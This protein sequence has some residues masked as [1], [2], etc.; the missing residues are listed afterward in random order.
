MKNLTI[1]ML[2]L[3]V[4]SCSSIR[5]TSDFEKSTD[6]TAYKTYHYY[7]D[8][9]SGLSQL[10]EKR[11]ISAIDSVMQSKGYS[12]AETADFYINVNS[13]QFENMNGNSI[14]VGV[15]GTGGNVGGGFSIGFPMGRGGLTSQIQLEFIDE[16]KQQLLWT[17][18]SES[19]FPT[20]ATPEKRKALLTAITVKMLNKFPPEKKK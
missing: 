15:G 18:T 9:N 14:G 17:A 7:K 3:F 13:D 1:L 12:L 11:L 19:N 5:V 10:D 2:F 4:T 6:F 8:L 16:N 20:K